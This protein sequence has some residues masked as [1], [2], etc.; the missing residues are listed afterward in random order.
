MST[1]IIKENLDEVTS[2][3]TNFG[4]YRSVIFSNKMEQNLKIEKR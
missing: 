4:R 1:L 2:S 3:F